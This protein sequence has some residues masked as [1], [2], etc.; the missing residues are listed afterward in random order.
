M[1]AIV[2]PSDPNEEKDFASW[3]SRISN[4]PSG[5]TENK[6]AAAAADWILNTYLD[7]P[8]FPSRQ[9]YQGKVRPWA[10]TAMVLFGKLGTAVGS[11]AKL[12]E[13]T[14]CVG[15]WDNSGSTM[16]WQMTIS[17][18]VGRYLFGGLI[19]STD[20]VTQVGLFDITGVSVGENP[21]TATLKTNNRWAMFGASPQY[22][23]LKKALEDIVAGSY[24]WPNN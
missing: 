7:N 11:H 17:T 20:T 8:K 9:V 22:D 24:T 23:A 15:Y 2:Q 19:D 18:G 5:S 6:E 4:P 14:E 13:D 21:S 10:Q 1:T 3:D 12:G 16:A